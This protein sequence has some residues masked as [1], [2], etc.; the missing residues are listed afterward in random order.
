MFSEGLSLYKDS[1]ELTFKILKI[2]DNKKAIDLKA[3]Y[4]GDLT[5]V[6]DYF[7]IASGTS[8][9]HVKSLCDE[10]EEK[11]NEDGV[12]VNHIEGYNSARWILMDYGNVVV[13]I[14]TKDERDFYSLERLWSDAK[15]IVL[16]KLIFD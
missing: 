14:F 9:T 7:I 3:L 16:D 4:V 15:E 10:V 8:I 12:P 6:A 2:L 11:L 1:S 5:T 13:H